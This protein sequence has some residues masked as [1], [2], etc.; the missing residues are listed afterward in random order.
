L[1]ILTCGD[2]K[3][4]VGIFFGKIGQASQL[5]TGHYSCR[6]FGPHH[7]FPILTLTINSLLQA[8]PFEVVITD[9]APVQAFY[10]CGEGVNFLSD[11]VR[12]I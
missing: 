8:K 6:Q 11:F 9:F 2:V 12:N 3:D 4:S 1:D 7:L 5:I 10:F